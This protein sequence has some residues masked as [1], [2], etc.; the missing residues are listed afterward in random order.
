[1]EQYGIPYELVINRVERDDT[2]SDPNS[3]DQF[4]DGF[5]PLHVYVYEF[6]TTDS[7]FE[8]ACKIVSKT[9]STQ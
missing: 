5:T 8:F 1:M 9:F 4:P 3:C 7:H 6:L 2:P